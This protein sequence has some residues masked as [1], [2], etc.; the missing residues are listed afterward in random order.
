M[1]SHMSSKQIYFIM[2]KIILLSAFILIIGNTFAQKNIVKI[3][4]IVQLKGQLIELNYE[5]SLGGNFSAGIGIAP[6]IFKPILG[7]LLYPPTNFNLGWAFDPEIRWYAKSDKVMD[8]FFIGL[9][10]SSRF[11]SWTGLSTVDILN[12]NSTEKSIKNSKFIYGFQLGTERM[13]GK[14]FVFDFYAGLGYANSIYKVT[15][16]NT[17]VETI[18]K[19]PGINLRLNIAFGYRF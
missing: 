15:D 12:S 13:M 19:V 18:D 6:I 5:R 9:Y 4:P 7:S 11:S 16:L 2:R 10:N 8:G 1:K 14:H 3:T 17:K